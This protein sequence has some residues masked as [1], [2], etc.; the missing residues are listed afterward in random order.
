MFFEFD[1]EVRGVE[2]R[3]RRRRRRFI[4]EC[5]EV[6]HERFCD[7][8]DDVRGIREERECERDFDDF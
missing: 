4:C 3:R 2:E 7:D 8:F 6:R 1:E 5:R